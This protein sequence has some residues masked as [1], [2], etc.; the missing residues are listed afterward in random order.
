MDD[1]HDVLDVKVCPDPNVP[2][3]VVDTP[4][5]IRRGS[6]LYECPSCGRRKWVPPRPPRVDP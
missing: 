3:V 5:Q 2:L 4:E 1:F 6:T